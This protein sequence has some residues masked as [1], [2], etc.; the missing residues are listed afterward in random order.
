MA[1]DPEC[2]TGWKLFEQSIL[3]HTISLI[4]HDKVQNT[5]SPGLRTSTC[6]VTVRIH[7]LHSTRTVPYKYRFHPRPDVVTVGLCLDPY[8]HILYIPPLYLG[9]NQRG[10]TVNEHVWMDGYVLHDWAIC[11]L[12][13]S[14][15]SMF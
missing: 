13:N 1:H 12:E 3:N 8:R 7:P 14:D 9:Y 4:R 6:T 2:R 15:G 5:D 10:S 11:Y